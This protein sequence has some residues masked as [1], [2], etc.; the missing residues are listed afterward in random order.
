M[1]FKKFILLLILISYLLVNV[2]N[3]DELPNGMRFKDEN[4]PWSAS[5]YILT[6]FNNI[7][8]IEIISH[9]HTGSNWY[10]LHTLD[11][12]QDGTLFSDIEFYI[13][14]EKKDFN[15][16]FMLEIKNGSFSI[17]QKKNIS[18]YKSTDLR[19]KFNI[20][21]NSQFM[22]VNKNITTLTYQ[23]DFILRIDQL[24]TQYIFRVPAV[25]AQNIKLKF[26]NSFFK[27]PD[28]NITNVPVSR[29][30]S[31]DKYV[32]INYVFW[33]DYLVH[34]IILDDIKFSLY[35][36]IRFIFQNTFSIEYDTVRWD[37]ILQAVVVAILLTITFNLGT[38]WQRKSMSIEP[39]KPPK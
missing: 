10:N 13:E 16:Y 1:K 4:L 22:F 9:I 5:T 25:N 7:A 34:K 33:N 18:N 35:P 32:E 20:K 28:N 38:L 15:E 19:F 14:S 29:I 17:H 37:W 2:G 27:L 23:S 3:A 6:P 26:Q 24:Y 31:T 8:Q 36:N 30:Y 11:I 12:N 21:P 39:I